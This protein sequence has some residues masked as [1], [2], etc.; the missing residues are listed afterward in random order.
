MWHGAPER[1][2]I[3]QTYPGDDDHRRHFDALLARCSPTRATS[4]STAGQCSTCRNPTAIP[5][6]ERWVALWQQL[7]D[8]AGL[9]GLFLVG[10][11]H[12]GP[13]EPQHHG[14]DGSVAIRLPAPDGRRGHGSGRPGS[15]RRELRRGPSR[16]HVARPT[17]STS[18]ASCP[19]GTTRRARNGVGWCSRARRRSCSASTSGGRSRRRR[20]GAGPPDRVGEVV[21]RVGRGQHPRTRPRVRARLPR[22]ASRRA[23]IRPRGAARRPGVDATSGAAGIRRLARI[24]RDRA[25]TD[26]RDP[27]R[28]EPRARPCRS[29]SAST[30]SPTRGWSIPLTTAARRATDDR[31]GVLHGL[32]GPNRPAHRG[33]RSTSTGSSAWTRRSRRRYG[34]AARL[35]RSASRPSSNGCVT[36][37]D[38]LGVHPHALAMGPAR[39]TAGSPTSP[40]AGVRPRMSRHRAWT[41][42]GPRSDTR[43]SCSA[44]ATRTSTTTS[45]TPRS[46]PGSAT[47]SRSSPG[48]RR[49]PYPRRPKAR[50][51]R[52]GC[53]TGAGYRACRT[54]PRPAT[55][56]VPAARPVRSGSCR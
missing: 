12:G 42:S 47:T 55:T 5:D 23:A 3:E 54:T 49:G 28:R 14:F 16:A 43:P 7:A 53:R 38:G 52:P 27:R 39:T 41:R 2:L 4:A 21:E 10:E 9:G 51:R 13:W 44:T 31:A 15:Q 25:Q 35:R 36:L 20:R 56:G 48:S 50:S 11:Y 32:A 22:S 46:T 17:T 34:D 30:A 33:L 26:R 29:C 40:N 19:G 8:A 37:G 1:M 18:R 45:S 6:V 24:A